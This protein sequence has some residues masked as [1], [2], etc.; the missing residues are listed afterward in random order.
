MDDKDLNQMLEARF[1]PEAP[2]NMAARIV[3]ASR[4]VEQHRPVE[5][6]RRWVR[7]FMDGLVFP[8]PEMALGAL[9]VFLLIGLSIGVFGESYLILPDATMDDLSLAFEADYTFDAGDFL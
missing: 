8:Q 2:S 1:V 9:G 3:E 7:G 6:L 5:G 4:H